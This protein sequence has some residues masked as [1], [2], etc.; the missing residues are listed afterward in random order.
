ME[1]VNV[2][3]DDLFGI[4]VAHFDDVVDFFVNLVCCTKAKAPIIIPNAETR[5]KATSS[6]RLKKSAICGE[7]RYMIT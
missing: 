4:C 5:V 6:S 3:V 2:L 1:Y 7:Q